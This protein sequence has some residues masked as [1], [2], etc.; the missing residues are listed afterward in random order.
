MMLLSPVIMSPI[1]GSMLW[2]QRQTV[3]ESFRPVAT[4]GA[5]LF[6]LLGL[7]QVMGNSFGFDRDGFRVFV[8]WPHPGETS[9][10]ARICRSPRSSL[11]WRFSCWRSWRPCVPCGSIICLALIPQYVSMF[12]LFCMCAEPYVDLF[13]CA[14]CCW[15][16]A[17]V[18]PQDG[19][20][21]LPDG[22]DD[23]PLTSDPGCHALAPG[24]GGLA[25]V[26]RLRR[27]RSVYLLL[28]L[29]ESALI[30]LIYRFVLGI[31]GNDLRAREQRI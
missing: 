5:M 13:R 25:P 20:R 18:E 4:A 22:C 3:P 15:F 17:A 16:A 12:L 11:L 30:M 2:R 26:S 8:L 23:D 31:Q 21:A 27:A 6:V 1:L 7:V 28:S 24:R 29:V 10:W 19:N 14:C 9:C